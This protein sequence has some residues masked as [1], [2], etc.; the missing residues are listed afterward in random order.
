MTDENNQGKG[1]RPSGRQRDQQVPVHPSSSSFV[2]FVRH[3]RPSFSSLIFVRHLRPAFP[4]RPPPPPPR[5]PACDA[6]AKL[7]D[8]TVPLPILRRPSGRARHAPA[9]RR[10]QL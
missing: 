10:L 2:I 6:A 5:D 3:F 7:R 9:D 4:P 1:G 8:L